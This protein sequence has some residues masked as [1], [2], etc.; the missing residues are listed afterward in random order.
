MKIIRGSASRRLAGE[1][2]KVLGLELTKTEFQRFPDGEA[3]VRI[4][5]DLTG[6]KVILVQTTHPDENIVE[7]FLWQDAINEYEIDSLVTI[8]PYFGYARQDKAF[9]PGEAIS[10]R[11][12]AERMELFSDEVITIDIHN[13]QVLDYFDKPVASLSAA[14]A[15]ARYF[16]GK[17]D[18]ILSPDKGGMER[19]REASEIL[20]CDFDYLEKTRLNAETVEMQPK[21]LSVEGKRVAIVDDI[22]STGG[23]VALAAKQLKEQGAV[24]IRAACTHGLFAGNVFDKLYDC[25]EVVATDT[26]ESDASKISVAEE[27]ANIFG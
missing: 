6:E 8:T 26:V 21:T 3:Y 25:N 2:A 18:V 15:F 23:T 11:A 10:A 17:V 7:L 1:L 16:R 5:E 14:P 9:N 24:E 13:K 22:I 12:I 20:G 19:A 27:I 4:L